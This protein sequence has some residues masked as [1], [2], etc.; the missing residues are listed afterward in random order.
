[1]PF[2]E[3]LELPL[4]GH[5]VGLLLKQGLKPS[6]PGAG[7]RRA[8]PGAHG[9]KVVFLYVSGFPFQSL[10]FCAVPQAMNLKGYK[11]LNYRHMFLLWG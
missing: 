4:N 7:L 6:I 2:S 5:P 1:M 8:R 11:S 10:C 3:E 9:P